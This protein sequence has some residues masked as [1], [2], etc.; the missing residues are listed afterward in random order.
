MLE[1]AQPEVTTAER[2]AR[3]SLGDVRASMPQG[4]RRQG[5]GLLQ[6][7]ALDIMHQGHRAIQGVVHSKQNQGQG[8]RKCAHMPAQEGLTSQR[9]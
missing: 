4:R 9:V 2:V 8:H 7:R 6:Q 1:R 5:A 3:P